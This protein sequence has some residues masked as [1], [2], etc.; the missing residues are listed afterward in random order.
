MTP[1]HTYTL[2]LPHAALW[3]T[4]LNCATDEPHKMVALEGR[5]VLAVHDAVE[6]DVQAAYR[7]G[8]EDAA[9]RCEQQAGTVSMFANSKDASLHNRAVRGCA[10]AIRGMME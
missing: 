9:K 7:K 5:T 6:R 8:L 1:D 4:A 3:Q 10:S 2:P